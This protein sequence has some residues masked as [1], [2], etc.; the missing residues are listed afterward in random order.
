MAVTNSRGAEVI[1]DV[2]SAKAKGG[3][4]LPSLQPPMNRCLWVLFLCAMT[5][6]YGSYGVLVHA[7]EVNGELPY[8]SASVVLLIEF[9]KVSSWCD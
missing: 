2:E 8:S 7:C 3:P 4:S 9:F 6:M 1:D 5:I